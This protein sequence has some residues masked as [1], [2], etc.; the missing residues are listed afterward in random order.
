MSLSGDID[1]LNE[2]YQADVYYEARW[3]EVMPLASLD[4]ESD[5]KFQ[6]MNENVTVR[7][8]K[9]DESKYWTPQLFIENAIGQ[10]GDQE[11]WFT[12]TRKRTGTAPTGSPLSITLEI[13]EH[14]RVKGV[15]W[16]KLE[17]N[18]VSRRQEKD[19]AYRQESLV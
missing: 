10:I 11:K 15:F 18:Y 1:T 7:Q 2:K 14:R 9:I 12:M 19:E 5:K 8:D 17:L 6:L 16:E 13:C 4:L 3:I